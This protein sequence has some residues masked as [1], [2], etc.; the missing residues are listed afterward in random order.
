MSMRAIA[1]RVG[2][3][4][5]ATRGQWFRERNGYGSA[6]ARIRAKSPS[7]SVHSATGVQP[8]ASSSMRPPRWPYLWL[9]SVWMLEPLAKA[10]R[11]P[12]MVNSTS[13]RRDQMHL[14]PRQ[15]VVPAGL[16]AEGVDRDVAAELAVDAVEQI[17]VE[18][19]G[20]AFRI[21]IGGDQPLDRP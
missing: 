14:D 12:S 8:P 19:G 3:A 5:A 6:S 7:S 13:R 10:K 16:V 9:F 15:D 17:E 20:H 2:L 4:A 21:V 18:L 11:W 1:M